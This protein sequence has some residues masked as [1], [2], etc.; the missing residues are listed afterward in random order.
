MFSATIQEELSTFVKA[1]LKDYAFVKLDSEYT[2]SEN[3]ALFFI[4]ARQS[5]KLASLIYILKKIEKDECSIIF[6]P[7]KYH[8]DLISEVLAKFEIRNVGIYGKMDMT[9]RQEQVAIF[10]KKQIKILVV[11]DLASR[12]IDL[13]FVENVIHFDYPQ[14]DKVF[15]HRSGRTSRAGRKGKIY[16]LMSL[17]EVAYLSD[18][19]LF[20]GRKAS[21]KKE[22]LGDNTKAFCGNLPMILLNEVNEALQ[23][24]FREDIECEN[25]LRMATR[26]YEKFTKTRSAA[27]KFSLKNSCRAELETPNP[28]FLDQVEKYADQIDILQKLKN[29]KPHASYL[30]LQ[31]EKVNK[32]SSLT[33]TLLNNDNPQLAK[34][35]EK[36]KNFQ[37][38]VKEIKKVETQLRDEK[39]KKQ[40]LRAKRNQVLQEQRE[41]GE[42]EQ[43]DYEEYYTQKYQAKYKPA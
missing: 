8:V 14:N 30:S 28:V 19:L 1:G 10:K 35:L 15:I 27:S 4:F 26:A 42:S 11:T 2:L 43:E 12:G 36:A 24:L 38:A 39:E 37:S 13:P 6:A 41:E 20:V 33:S 31:S 9:A 18:L 17:T 22:E 23:Q 25:L 29:F 3:A 16:C 34:T 7:T 21:Y 5:D 32:K 40:L